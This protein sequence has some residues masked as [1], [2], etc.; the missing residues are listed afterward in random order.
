MFISD[1]AYNKDNSQ[2]FISDLKFGINIVQL[3][4]STSNLNVTLDN[5][6]YRKVGCNVIVYVDGDLYASCNDLFKVR[7]DSD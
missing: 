6:G 1:L 7:Y 2:I 5:R 3:N 4:T